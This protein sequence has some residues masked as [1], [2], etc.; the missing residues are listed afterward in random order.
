[1]QFQT[2]LS[3]SRRRGFAICVFLTVLSGCNGNA[4]RKSTA[5]PIVVTK[6][7]SLPK[8]EA[9]AY[10]PCLIPEDPP[11]HPNYTLPIR[12]CCSMQ[13]KNATRV[14]QSGLTTT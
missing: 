5:E 1:M 6:V 3:S 10:L 14:T 12:W 2:L 4:P 9:K 13:L 11:E 8:Q 7:V